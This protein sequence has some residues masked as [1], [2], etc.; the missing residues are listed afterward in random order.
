M[1]EIT[2]YT[3]PGCPYCARAKEHYRQ[4]GIAFD[5]IDVYTVPG[6]REDAIAA[7]GGK[8]VVPVIVEKGRVKI[9]FDGW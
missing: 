6:A 5:E 2:I 8:A 7:A 4:K 9:G 1:S 3:K